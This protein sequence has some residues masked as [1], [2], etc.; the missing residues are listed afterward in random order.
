LKAKIIIVFIVLA[1]ATAFVQKQE[2]KALYTFCGKSGEC[3]MTFDDWK[4]CS[5]ELI[6]ISK[7]FK[8]NSFKIQIKSLSLW[9]NSLGKK[10]TVCDT[11]YNVGAVFSDDNI[12][13]IENSVRAKRLVGKLKIIA[14][15]VLS[16]NKKWMA[17]DMSIK[18]NE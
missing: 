8:I 17:P 18:I 9:E 15:D 13:R 14:V 2:G 5:K 12:R 10:D 3:T 1:T 4:N 7:S 6:P 16:E 11:I